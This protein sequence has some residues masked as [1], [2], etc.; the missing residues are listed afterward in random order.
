MTLSPQPPYPKRLHMGSGVHYAPG[1]LN[2]DSAIQDRQDMHADV[3]DLPLPDNYFLRIY[4]G[5]FLEHL[6][7]DRIPD[8]M[9]ELVRVATPDAVF[10]IVGPCYELALET[11][12][13]QWLLDD[14]I[15]HGPPPGGHAW[16]ATAQL[17]R[18]VLEQSGLIVTP[19]PLGH[20][21]QPN[22]P[23]PDHMSNWQCAMTATIPVK[24]P[25]DQ[26]PVAAT[27]SD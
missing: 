11:N 17:T 22:W 14:I 10:G 26:A 18:K 23:N 12:Q 7:F 19:E 13:P 27:A 9:R 8:A 6:E 5:H 16:T 1:W 4:L 3:Y 15:A 25:H 2:V 21:C 20:L 24:E